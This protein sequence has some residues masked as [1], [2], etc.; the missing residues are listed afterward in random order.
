M[1]EKD[2][3]WIVNPGCGVEPRK[4]DPCPAFKAKVPCW[5]FNWRPIAHACTFDERSYW[6]EFFT[7]QC[8]HQRCPVYLNHKRE[9]NERIAAFKY[10]DK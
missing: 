3:C 10:F 1:E 6:S 5:R 9:N 8:V 4:C 7:K 2:V